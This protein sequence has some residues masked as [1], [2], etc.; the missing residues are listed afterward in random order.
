MSRRCDTTGLPPTTA[1][2]LATGS[3]VRTIACR[4]GLDVPRV[5]RLRYVPIDRRVRELVAIPGGAS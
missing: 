3:D 1:D 2:A 4:G 5:V